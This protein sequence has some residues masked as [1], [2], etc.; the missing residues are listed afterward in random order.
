MADAEHIGDDDF[1][2]EL[3]PEALTEADDFEPIDEIEREALNQDLVDVKVLKEVLAARGIKGIVVWCPDCESDHYLGWDLLAGNLQR[4]LAAGRPPV[5]EPAFEPDPDEY[6]SWDYA[7]GFLDGFDAYPTEAAGDEI[8][9][10]CGSALPEGG[11]QWSHC[12]SCGSE[13]APINLIRELRRR[14]WTLED[15]T[16]LMQEAGF[17]PPLIDLAQMKKD[18]ED[19]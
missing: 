12:P 16:V 2:T 17:E 14:D 15:I 13:L 4:I 1:E 10:F 19:E 8:C 6:V 9:G 18:D 7:R 11:Y 5:H 3:T